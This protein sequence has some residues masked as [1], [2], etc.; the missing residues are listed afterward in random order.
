MQ[1]AVFEVILRH[2]DTAGEAVFRR[3]IQP[4]AVLQGD[5]DTRIVD[6]HDGDVDEHIGVEYVLVHPEAPEIAVE[7][8]TLG[9][10]DLH[11]VLPGAVEIRQTQVDVGQ[12]GIGQQRLETGYVP[13][14]GPG[15][16]IP[17]RRVGE[18]PGHGPRA[19][20]T[21]DDLDIAAR[22]FM[23]N[24]GNRLDDAN[25]GDFANAG[26]FGVDDVRFDEDAVTRSD[27]PFEAADEID[28]AA[29]H[30]LDLPVVEIARDT[31]RRGQCGIVRANDRDPCLC[32][33]GDGVEQSIRGKL[34]GTGRLQSVHD[35]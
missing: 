18:F 8:A 21:D 27:Q 16:C 30:R 5:G 26:R 34:A 20:F 13:E 1:Q 32:G 12:F 33:R 11:E 17:R 7:I 28:G 9:D 14:F 23:D 6:L 19:P 35:V 25:V 22:D 31:C 10:V 4:D 29:H 3:R 24:A 2:A 15:G